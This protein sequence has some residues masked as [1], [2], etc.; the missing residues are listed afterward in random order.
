[1]TDNEYNV[2]TE[3]LLKAL[4]KLKTGGALKLNVL[5][6]YYK[7]T[8]G[9]LLS[10]FYTYNIETQGDHLSHHTAKSAENKHCENKRRR[11]NHL[12]V[13]VNGTPFHILE[14]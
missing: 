1:M 9:T 11:R 7:Y 5:K 4:D 6:F 13:L 2:Q 3:T 12:P 10:Y 8:H 14:K